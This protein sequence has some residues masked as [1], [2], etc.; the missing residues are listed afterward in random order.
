[1]YSKK[2]MCAKWHI[3]ASSVAFA[4]LAVL[5]LIVPVR[6]SQQ[7][8]QKQKQQQK[9]QHQQQQQQRQQQRQEQRQQQQQQQQQ[10]H[11]QQQLNKLPL[12]SQWSSYVVSIFF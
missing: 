11:Q 1:M 6:Q 4:L 12:D 8:I 10:Q 7:A 2:A 5:H 3:G 9:Q